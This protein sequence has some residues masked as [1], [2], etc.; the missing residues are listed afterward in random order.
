MIYYTI[1]VPHYGI[2][3][4][5]TIQELIA[6]VDR[7]CSWNSPIVVKVTRW[8][9]LPDETAKPGSRVTADVAR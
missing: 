6:S 4:T 8:G 5:C 9:G 1:R 3:D 2:F 7:I